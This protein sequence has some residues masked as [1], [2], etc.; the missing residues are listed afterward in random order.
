MK[1]TVTVARTRLVIA[2]SDAEYSKTLINDMADKAH[3]LPIDRVMLLLASSFCA[4]ARRHLE[5]ALS[6][7]NDIEQE[8]EA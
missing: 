6:I 8:G 4:T 3:H 2:S 5:Q 7:I 1:T